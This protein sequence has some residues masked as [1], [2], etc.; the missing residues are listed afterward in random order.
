[1]SI[2]RAFA[3]L[4][5]RFKVAATAPED[6]QVLTFNSGSGEYEPATPSSGGGSAV[7]I[8]D[9]GSN[10][11]TAL[12]SI[13]FTGAGVTATHT[14]DAV[15]V[16]IPGGGG[17]LTS[18]QVMDTIAAML[19]AGTNI[20]LTYNDAGDQLTV[21]SSGS[22]SSGIVQI[23]QVITSGSQANVTFSSIPATYEDL[24]IV[25]NGRCDK[26]G[27]SYD[28]FGMQINADTGN[29]YDS[30]GTE[31]NNTSTTAT[32]NV[33]AAW[34]NIGWLPGATAP[35]NVSGCTE[36]TIPNYRRTTFQK[37]L[38]GRCALNLSNAAG[39]L[40]VRHFG[41]WWRSTTAI[42]SVKVFPLASNFANNSVV[43]LY[44]RT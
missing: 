23:A 12:A 14:G 9:E 3:N 32:A 16:D 1:M 20:T 8:K 33:A 13:D 40:F 10:L 26:S 24:I 7:T 36:I 4:A 34:I 29:N 17:G 15:T 27:A 43:T 28:D 5:Q 19:V 18:E 37:S 30:E 21:A 31:S 2:I 11:T 25:I 44:G 39:G 6:G 35:A 41:G 38:I 22:G 42:N